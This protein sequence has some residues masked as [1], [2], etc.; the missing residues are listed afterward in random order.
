MPRR[1]GSLRADD[2]HVDAARLRPRDDRRDIRDVMNEH[3]LRY[4]ADSRVL[5]SHHRIE[6]DSALLQ[7]LHDRVFAATPADDEDLHVP[8]DAD[9]R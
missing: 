6:L 7:R 3:V 1:K 4:A 5:V 8:R 2:G 9:R